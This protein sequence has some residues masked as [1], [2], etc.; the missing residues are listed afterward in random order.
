MDKPK[1]IIMALQ[2]FYIAGDIKTVRGSFKFGEATA[3]VGDDT[4]LIHDIT[5]T[6][7]SC[8]WQPN[9]QYC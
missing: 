8:D 3:K 4:F 5:H 9:I 7:F 6:I 2:H 1:A